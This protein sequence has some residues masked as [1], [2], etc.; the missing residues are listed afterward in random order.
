MSENSCSSI[1][2]LT[3]V[4]ESKACSSYPLLY[5]SGFVCFTAFP[6]RKCLFH[7]ILLLPLSTSPRF[8]W[9]QLIPFEYLPPFKLC[10]ATAINF[11]FFCWWT[12][13]FFLVCNCQRELCCWHSWVCL[14]GVYL[15]MNCIRQLFWK[16]CSRWQHVT[17]LS[18]GTEQV[19]PGD[20]HDSECS[21]QGRLCTPGWTWAAMMLER[22]LFR[23]S[24]SRGD[25]GWDS[26]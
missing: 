2:S 14:L 8:M 15:A 6:D 24:G 4:L 16:K 23:G 3:F 7:V 11:T 20:L 12:F 19:R 1:L 25:V 10:V 21:C 9:L 17:C 22:F 5:R 13:D 18:G 26:S